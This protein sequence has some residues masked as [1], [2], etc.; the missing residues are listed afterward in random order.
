[1]NLGEILVKFQKNN[2]ESFSFSFS[3]LLAD[4]PSCRRITT[5]I[6]VAALLCAVGHRSAYRAH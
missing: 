2:Q 5:R 3:K 6:R 4:G 1:M